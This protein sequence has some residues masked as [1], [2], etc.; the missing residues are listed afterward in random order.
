MEQGAEAPCL[1]NYSKNKLWLEE[2]S[3]FKTHI[4]PESNTVELSKIL[5]PDVIK[6]PRNRGIQNPRK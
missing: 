4:C 5:S 1:R 2:F 6:N 3:I